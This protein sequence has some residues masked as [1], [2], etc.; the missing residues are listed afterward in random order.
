MQK[1]PLATSEKN[2]HHAATQYEQLSSTL[3]R[4]SV[5]DV[6]RYIPSSIQCLLWG[7]AAGRCE[8]CN[9]PL[10][11]SAVTQ[12]Q[13]KLAEL[14]HIYSFS[15]DGPRGNTGIS[16]KKINDIA[17]L[18]LV[19]RECHKT[20][21]QDTE[22]EQYSA[23]LLCELKRRHERRIDIITGIGLDRTS[24]VLHYGANVGDHSSPL[25]FRLT[26]LALFPDRYPADD[27]AIELTTINSSFNE[28]DSSFWSTESHEL[29]TKFDQRV[30]ERLATG[31][32]SHLSIFALAPQPLL[33][34]LGSL[35]TDIPQADV[36]QLHR[37]PQGWSW[38][39]EA[40]IIP[41]QIDEPADTSG[42]PALVLSLSATIT[43]DRIQSALGQKAA[44]WSV[45]I[46]SP[47]ND[48][49]KSRQQLALFRSHMRPLLDRIKSRHGQKTIL[50]IF[51]AAP[52]SIAV[53]LGRVRMP[54]ADMPWAIYDQINAQGGFVRTLTIP[55]GVEA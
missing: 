53:E 40:K 48:F 41:Y 27:K 29:T 43:P 14:A 39:D 16:R 25:K 54:K 47:H 10:W 21:D 11:K 34:L 1:D 38:P 6:T 33:I 7:R 44:I 51:P 30:H 2:L 17:N 52:V 36:Y 12:E 37:E 32:I 13:V 49:L 31:E 3:Q 9:K 55:K 22:G 50:H 20:I 18:L 24:H 19:C 46:M 26:A 4:A 5:A 42:P 8:F 28:R 45:G 23:A 15:P 35:L